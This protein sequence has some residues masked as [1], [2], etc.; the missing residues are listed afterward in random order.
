MPTPLHESLTELADL[1][2]TCASP[3][4][5]KGVI[6]ESHELMRKALAHRDDPATLVHWYSGVVRDVLASPGVAEL[7]G[8]VDLV[9]TGPLGRQEALPGAPVQWLAPGPDPE[10]LSPVGLNGRAVEPDE[11]ALIDASQHAPNGHDPALLRRA[12]GHRPAGLHAIDGLPDHSV[13]AEVRGNLLVPVADVAR[14]A[15]GSEAGRLPRTP[16][17]LTAGV[18]AGVLTEN[19]RADL[20][21]AWHTALGLSL[22]RW[23]DRVS[24]SGPL[25]E[26]SGLD[27]SAYGESG[28]TIGAVIRALATRNDIDLSELSD[29]DLKEEYY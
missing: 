28:R 8:G 1:A 12:V 29:G 5:A 2:P 19:E 17:R 7:T 3:A 14:W 15:A 18:T 9:P 4:T 23:V 22:R 11:L 13:L 6:A 27:R 16:D 10:T 20:E 26:L 24:D 21:Q 25:S